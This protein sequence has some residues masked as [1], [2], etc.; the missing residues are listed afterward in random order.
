MKKIESQNSNL[1]SVSIVILNYEGGY[2]F[3]KCLRSV[4]SSVYDFY[5]VI[6][7]DN[8][9]KDG[10]Y[11]RAKNVFGK[12][13]NIT[14]IKNPVNY[15][16]PFGYN[17]GMREAKGQ[18]IVILNNDV[19]VTPYWLTGL[20]KE[21]IVK[22]DGFYAP[23]ILLLDDPKRLDSAGNHIHLSGIGFARGLSEVDLNQHHEVDEI[24]Y[25]CG[26]CCLLSRNMID[27]I[28]AMDPVYFAFHEDLDWGWRG[29]LFGFKSYY[30]PFSVV[31]HR[32]GGSWGRWSE[33]K[34]YLMERNRLLTLLKNYSK[35][36]LL[37]LSPILVLVEL[38][39]L[40]FSIKNRFFRTKIRT[41]SDLFRLKEYTKVQ[42]SFIQKHRKC[43]DGSIICLFSNEIKH[44]F[45]EESKASL[46][47]LNRLFRY[48]GSFVRKA[49]I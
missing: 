44:Q 33:K 42:R 9:S 20:I 18:Y 27:E 26:T 12:E 25:A 13:K 29:K 5:D 8:A 1:P 40:V 28:G 4:L 6:V 14:F 48:L 23:K 2:L 49:I 16:V 39:I 15:G 17:I 21:A 11:E 38:A 24:A 19:I 10:S 31:Y 36:T 22:G 30:V 32:W 43:S 37:M 41:Y 3:L 35:G 34:F 45:F 47:V 46:K 7:V